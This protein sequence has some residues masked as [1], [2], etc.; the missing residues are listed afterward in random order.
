MSKE[1]KKKSSNSSPQQYGMEEPHEVTCSFGDEKRPSEQPI[2]VNDE[3]K[4]VAPPK[5]EERRER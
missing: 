2:E 3:F 1:E 5:K 4:A